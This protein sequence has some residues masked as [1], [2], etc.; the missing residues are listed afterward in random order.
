MAYSPPNL[1]TLNPNLTTLNTVWEDLSLVSPIQ[2]L[3]NTPWIHSGVRKVES[4]RSTED[5]LALA[6]TWKRL[7]DNNI[8]HNVSSLK[9]DELF[10]FVIEEDRVLASTIRDYYSKKLMLTVLKEIPLTKFRKDLNNFIHSSGL[11][12][13]ESTI[14]MVYRLPEFYEYDT[15]MDVLRR[16]LVSIPS[17]QSFSKGSD[18]LIPVKYFK[19][20]LA[21]KVRHEY[22]LKTAKNHSAMILIDDANPL[23]HMWDREFAKDHIDIA[24]NY[25]ITKRDDFSF[26]T[27]KKWQLVVD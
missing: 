23:Q 11:E 12:F 24:A 7:R 9:D 10:K 19:R 22:W 20:K 14:P 2:V 4:F 18:S 6:V 17:T 27:L 25:I 5:L 26:Y 1:T 13:T 15:Q 3:D 16:D 8:T 21:G